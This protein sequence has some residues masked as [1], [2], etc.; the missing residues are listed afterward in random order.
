MFTQQFD[1]Y[2]CEY[3]GYV[4]FRFIN[5]RSKTQERM[6]EQVKREQCFH[7]NEIRHLNI[8]T[9]GYSFTYL[10]ENNNIP[11][12]LPRFST[13][14]RTSSY[15]F[16]LPLYSAAPDFMR[17]K[18]KKQWH[19]NLHYTKQHFTHLYKLLADELIAT[20]TVQNTRNIQ[21]YNT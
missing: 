11:D 9:T 2:W 15:V 3:K 21:Q 14:R 13:F 4:S 10:H 1:V 8:Q 18:A 7:L 16:E 6:G 20:Q 12:L 5:Q 19:T 17:L